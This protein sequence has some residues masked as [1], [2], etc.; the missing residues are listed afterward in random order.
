MNRLLDPD[1]LALMRTVTAMPNSDT[2]RLVAAD[3]LEERG[4]DHWP[5]LIRLQCLI[6][7]EKL[8]WKQDSWGRNL[9][10]SKEVRRCEELLP[11]VADV[12]VPGRYPPC[13]YP[14]YRA[15]T[16]TTNSSLNQYCQNSRNP[17]SLAWERG[18]VV[19]ANASL[20]EFLGYPELALTHPLRPHYDML[21]DD[22]V[23]SP[24]MVIDGETYTV[25]W[26]RQSKRRTGVPRSVFRHLTGK[27]F[28][29]NG[30]Q[31]LHRDRY[32]AKF[33][34]AAACLK[35]IREDYA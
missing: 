8:H 35:A 29:S 2:P 1:F 14:A 23:R 24:P 31:S 12:A 27:R 17:F 11:L 7:R 26:F 15:K 13:R 25:F 30:F 18:F 6:E 4:F 9:G 3:W 28:S 32:A 21:H 22:P 19:Q 20:H 34:L 16:M 5:E 10:V 33:D